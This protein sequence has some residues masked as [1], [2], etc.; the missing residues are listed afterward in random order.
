M[1]YARCNFDGQPMSPGDARVVETFAIWLG[2]DAEE[3]RDAVRLDPQ[4]RRFVAGEGGNAD[5]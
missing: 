4:W 2:M 5:P 1:A 3:R